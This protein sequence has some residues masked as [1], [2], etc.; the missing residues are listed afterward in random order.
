MNNLASLA[1]LP[2]KILQDLQIPAAYERSFKM[3]HRGIFANR[4]MLALQRRFL[5]GKID[6]I[7]EQLGCPEEASNEIKEYNQKA[8]M[9]AIGCEEANGKLSYRF[10]LDYYE[11]VAKERERICS[12]VQKPLLAFQGWKWKLDG[13]HCHRSDYW[14]QINISKIDLSQLIESTLGSSSLLTAPIHNLVDYLCADTKWLPTVLLTKDTQSSRSSFDLNL[15]EQRM[16]VVDVHGFLERVSN[17]WEL[18]PELL[19]QVLAITS[20]QPL[21]HISAGLSSQN[22]EFLTVYFDP[23]QS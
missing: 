23:N 16:N 10:Y 1:T 3:D 21:G 7:L 5:D 12:D 20:S 22:Y 13:V 11:R 17:G 4:Y 18:P 15:Y 6:T 2:F 19:R 9:A 14:Q 8:S